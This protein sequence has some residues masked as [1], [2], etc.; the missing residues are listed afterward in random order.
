MFIAI[1]IAI[2]VIVS[3]NTIFS[4]TQIWKPTAETSETNNFISMQLISIIVECL[5][6]GNN[7]HLINNFYK[8]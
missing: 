2:N 3:N 7:S 6:V 4:K 8:N 1:V 5:R